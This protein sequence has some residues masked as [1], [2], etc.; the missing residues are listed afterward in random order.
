MTASEIRDLKF[1]EIRVSLSGRLQAVYDAW[2][3]FGP[4]TTRQLAALSGIDILNVRPRT[5]DL[6]QLGLVELCGKRAAEGCYRA[7]TQEEWEGWTRLKISANQI[8]LL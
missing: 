3:Q 5:T 1:T 4:C 2:L 6:A 7:R 8:Q